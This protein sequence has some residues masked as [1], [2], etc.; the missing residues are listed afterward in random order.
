MKGGAAGLR[1]LN[2]GIALAMT[3]PTGRVAKESVLKLQSKLQHQLQHLPHVHSSGSTLKSRLAL[4]NTTSS[5]SSSVKSA[6]VAVQSGTTAAVTTTATKTSKIR[7]GKVKTTAQIQHIGQYIFSSIVDIACAFL[8]SLCSSSGRAL[9][10][11]VFVLYDSY[12]T[13]SITRA[14]YIITCTAE[15]CYTR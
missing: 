13:V 11:Q 12:T 15:Y 1:H 2:S 7:R 14:C 4:I 5:H 3:T 9:M 10:H 6:A 8:E